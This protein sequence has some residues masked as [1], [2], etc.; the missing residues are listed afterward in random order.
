MCDTVKLSYTVSNEDF[1]RAGE[2]DEK[3]GLDECWRKISAAYFVCQHEHDLADPGGVVKDL[4][5]ILFTGHFAEFFKLLIEL[6]I[7]EVRKK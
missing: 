3:S 7:F 2:F 6:R 4:F 1:T 5:R